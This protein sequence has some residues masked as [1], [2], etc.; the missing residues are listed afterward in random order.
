M[1]FTLNA[2]FEADDY[3]RLGTHLQVKRLINASL[4]VFFICELAPC[5]S[6]V[7]G[8]VDEHFSCQQIFFALLVKKTQYHLKIA[9]CFYFLL[10][11]RKYVFLIRFCV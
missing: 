2:L 10:I 1:G 3:A 11:E 4:K 8:K 7:S 9:Q 6:V 5:V